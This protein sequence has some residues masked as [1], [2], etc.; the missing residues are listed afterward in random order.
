MHEVL[1]DFYEEKP[2]KLTEHNNYPVKE[3][4]FPFSLGNIYC[5]VSV[6][7]AVI[8]MVRFISPLIEL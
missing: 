2:S 7:Q 3:Y 5:M 4:K 8:K 6:S 1:R